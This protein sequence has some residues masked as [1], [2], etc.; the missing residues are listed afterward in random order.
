MT[1]RDALEDHIW[2]DLEKVSLKALEDQ[3]GFLQFIMGGRTRLS[4]IW[5][6]T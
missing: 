3:L 5:M 1:S 2:V 6:L 4:W